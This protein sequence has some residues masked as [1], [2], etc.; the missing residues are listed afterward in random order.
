MT[1]DGAGNGDS[2]PTGEG[3]A[4]ARGV[5][6]TACQS[7]GVTGSGTALVVGAS[8][9]IGRAIAVR[10]A[11]SGCDVVA[12]GRDRAALD[13]TV[14]ACHR[15]GAG[16][17]AATLDVTDRDA[18]EELVGDTRDLRVAVW[19]AGVF[20][21]APAQEASP[22]RWAEVIDVNLTA[23]ATFTATVMPHLV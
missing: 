12:V 14:D 23:A 15:H 5:V 11:Q 16:A 13:R 3:T 18:V 4:S 6:L 17:R 9:E 10:L 19:A 1:R 7:G 21:W 20:D 22:G 2:T 8:S